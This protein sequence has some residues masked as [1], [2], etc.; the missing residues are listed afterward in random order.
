MRKKIVS[1]FQKPAVF[2]L[3]SVLALSACGSS[4]EEDGGE[5]STDEIPES[6][7][8]F[9]ADSDIAGMAS[10]S[11]D[12]EYNSVEESDENWILGP[13]VDLRITD[14]AQVPA[15]SAD[16]YEE[17]AGEGPG[18]N[19]DGERIDEVHAAE[20]HV[21]YVAKFSTD[22]PQWEPRGDIPASEARLMLGNSESDAVFNTDDGARNQGTL[23]AS[24]P[25]DSSEDSVS[26]EVE[27]DD[28]FQSL[29]L[30][31]GERLSSDV[32]Q[33]YQVHDK[34]AEVTSADEISETFEAWATGDDRISGNVADA[35]IVPWLDRSDGGDGWPSGD[36]IYLSVEVDWAKTESTT[37][38]ETKIY[39]ELEDGDTVYPTNNEKPPFK[40]NVVFEIPSETSELE[41]VMEPEVRVGGGGNAPNH[42][43]DDLIA[44]VEISDN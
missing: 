37:F 44:E 19:D 6:E 17:L 36:Q 15:I 40:D 43:W 11:V 2:A 10:S 35:F 16:V 32:E 24:M 4:D 21:F 42:T 9:R 12:A 5:S 38:D 7:V 1:R 20:D 27:T 26:L 8:D 3:A 25:E 29:S 33:V 22:D 18:T 13:G 31:T 39:V 28:K 30:V 34:D 41:V 23:I 14:V